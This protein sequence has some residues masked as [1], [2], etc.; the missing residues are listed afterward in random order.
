MDLGKRALLLIALFSLLP[1]DVYA[2]NHV[3]EGDSSPI[4]W[5]RAYGGAGTDVGLSM[6]RT[7]D[8]GYVIAGYTD[9]FGAGNS[10]VYLLKTDSEGGL[11]W[12]KTYGGAYSDLGYSVQ[13]TSD[14]GYIIAGETTSFGEHATDIY[15][16]K[17]DSEGNEIW[18]RKH[19][20]MKG[21]ER[22]YSVQRTIDG[23]YIVAGMSWPL[24]QENPDFYLLKTDSEG[25]KLWSRSYTGPDGHLSW[26][27]GR[28]AMETGE[29]GYVIVGEAYSEVERNQDILLVKT[30]SLGNLLWS[31]TYGGAD[32]EYG[33]SVLETGNGGYVIAG[34]TKSFGAGEYDVYVVK[35]K[36]LPVPVS[37]SC[38]ASVD[39]VKMGRNVVVSGVISPAT[40]GRNVTLT[41]TPPDGSE[42]V[43]NVEADEDGA[44]RDGYTPN[45]PGLWT[46]TASTESDV[47]YEV[48][49]SEPASFTAEEPLDVAPLYSYGLL[50]AVIVIAIL[51]AWWLRKRS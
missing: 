38:Q 8:G 47:Y 18:S 12:N 21:Y 24:E 32:H 39:K 17:I 50:A 33:Y 48:S 34:K 10:D 42:T 51:S 27:W 19:G 16:I 13:E 30:D 5:S 26:D 35:T 15:L 37:I 49:S 40:P 20:D 9:S 28:S 31:R 23:G 2:S 46:V 4:D 45:L 44:F 14:G 29:G 25:D 11:I 41:Y 6:Q 36:P 3:D 1:L 7:E 43:R 22:G